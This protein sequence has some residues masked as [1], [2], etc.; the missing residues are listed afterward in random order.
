VKRTPFVFAIIVLLQSVFLSAQIP[1]PT[2]T[3]ETPKN[4]LD[5]VHLGDVV[6]VDFAGGLEYDWRGSLTSDGMLGG[7]E[8]FGTIRA[9]C[10][11]ETA[12]A[13]DIERAYSKVLRDPKVTVKIVDRSNRPAARLDGAV[14]MPTR[15]RIQRPVRLRELIVAAGGFT[16]DASG[17]IVVLRPAGQS[18]ADQAEHGPD[19]APKSQWQES[20][21]LQRLNISIADLLTGKELADPFI[22]S[23]D[24]VTVEKAVP[25]YVIGAVNNP[26]PI[27]SRSG[28]TLTR[29]I[30]TAGGLA[31]GAIGQKVTIFRREK[32]ET[33]VMQADLEK[34]KNGEIND[35]DLKAFDIIEIAFKGRAARKYPPVIAT[36]EN[37][38]GG[39]SELPLRVID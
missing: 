34:I 29:A 33:T 39:A 8:E 37:G 28:M 5:L 21:G 13:A 24:I 18:C 30:D 17:E 7:V 32:A 14:K 25:I 15:F 1:A 3:P 6:D 12:I 16:D 31:K 38:Q 2:A 19:A 9:V 23:G 11:S 20:N 10:R 26:K 27:Y 22:L 35:V 36:G 4:E